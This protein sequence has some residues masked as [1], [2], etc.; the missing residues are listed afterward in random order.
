MAITAQQVNELRQRTGIPMMACKKALEEAGGDEEKAIEILRKKGATKAAEKADR[1]MREG[2]IVTKT[3]NDTAVIV[4]FSCETDFV[5]KN[6][7][8]TAIANKAAETALKSGVDVAKSEA[9]PSIKALFARLGENMSIEV[10]VI[11]GGGIGEYLHTNSKVGAIVNLKSKDA[12]KARDIAMHITAMNPEVISPED[13]PEDVV[14]KE[15]EIWADQLKS[16]G[17]P[18]EIM[19][20]IMQGKEKK[21]REEAALIKQTFVKDGEKT[22]EQYLE[23]NSVTSFVRKAV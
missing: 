23:S 4:K 15:R 20:R 1:A 12:E 6:E 19:D 17:K 10:D 11:E 21:F 7:E 14:I 8:F 13:L 18:A 3:K 22:V 2:I 9:E 16:E 5:A